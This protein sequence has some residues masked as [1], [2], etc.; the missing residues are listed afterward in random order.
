MGVG[1]YKK[2]R[3]VKGKANFKR[4]GNKQKWVEQKWALLFMG[5]VCTSMCAKNVSFCPSLSLY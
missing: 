2:V 5:V 1:N 4:R 3:L